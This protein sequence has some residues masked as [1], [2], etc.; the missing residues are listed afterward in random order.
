[1]FSYIFM[2]IL[3]Q[4]PRSYDRLMERFSSGRALAFKRA[5]AAELHAAKHVLEI[6]CGTGEL[7]GM[8]AAEGVR[9]DG[10]DIRPDMVKAAEER[11]LAEDLHDRVSVR[12]MGVDAMDALAGACYDAVV[13]TLVLSELSEDERHFAL[14]HAA[15]VLKTNGLIVIAD[16]VMPR[17]FIKKLTYFMARLP[18]GIFTYL[19]ARKATRPLRSISDELTGA[20]FR[21]EKEIRSHGD[22]FALAVGRLVM[23]DIG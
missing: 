3:E 19:I 6:G 21:V 1:L 22:A 16:E 14:R 4:R 9:V 10:F 13:A 18:L 17:N 2:K 7:A 20:G 11:I 15:R 23:K 5:A 8:L 12:L